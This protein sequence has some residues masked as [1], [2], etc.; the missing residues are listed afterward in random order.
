VADALRPVS[1]AL[2]EVAETLRSIP[3]MV[4]VATD[5]VTERLEEVRTIA[6]EANRVATTRHDHGEIA[7]L[8]I[9]PFEMEPVEEAFDPL[10]ALR[11]A[12]FAVD[13]MGGAWDEAA[14]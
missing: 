9:V 10:T 8:P 12:R 11:R 3:Y 1:V 6:E 14:S 4:A 7:V 2:G 13:E 5:H